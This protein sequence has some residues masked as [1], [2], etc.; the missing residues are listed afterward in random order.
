MSRRRAWG[1]SGGDSPPGDL[2]P[3][4]TASLYKPSSDYYTISEPR[5]VTLQEKIIQESGGIVIADQEKAFQM[6]SEYMDE[7]QKITSKL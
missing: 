3:E 1:A 5:H 7:L 2:E 6:S 4:A